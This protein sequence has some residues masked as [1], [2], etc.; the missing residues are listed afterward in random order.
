MNEGISH[1]DTPQS[2]CGF[3]IAHGEITPPAEIYCRMWGA[4]THD[5]ATGVHRPLRATVI[6]RG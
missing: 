5:R 2:I 6:V 3:G 1:L 4:A